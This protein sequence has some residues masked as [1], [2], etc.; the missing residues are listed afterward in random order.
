MIGLIDEVAVQPGFQHYNLSFPNTAANTSHVLGF[1]LDPFTDVQSSI[2]LTNVF[3]GF[4]GVSQSPLLTVATNTS[5][6]LLVYKLTGQLGSYTVQASADLT[7]TNWINIAILANT[8]G[9]V[10]FI[11]PNSTNYPCRFYRAVAQ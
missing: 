7:S 5:N 2:T 8:T 3:T 6:G 1:H 4:V 9:T 10:T 11:D